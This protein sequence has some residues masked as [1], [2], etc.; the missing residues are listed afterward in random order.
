M[1]IQRYSDGGFAIHKALPNMRISGY[2]DRD[3]ALLDSEQFNT[4]GR[5]QRISRENTQKLMALGI[6]TAHS[7]NW[8]DVLIEFVCF[9]AVMVLMLLMLYCLLMPSI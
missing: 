2:Y 8:R 1:Q 6:H 9:S 3:G 7:I 4:S 5:R